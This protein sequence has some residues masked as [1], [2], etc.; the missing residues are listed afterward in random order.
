MDDKQRRT[1]LETRLRN[2]ERRYEKTRNIEL[3]REIQQI[4]EALAMMQ[5]Q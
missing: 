3:K 1:Y 4:K 2:I 5:I